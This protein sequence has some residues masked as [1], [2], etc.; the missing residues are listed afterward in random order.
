MGHFRC[1]GS[2][3]LAV[4]GKTRIMKKA[5][6]LMIASLVVFASCRK[7]AGTLPEDNGCGERVII[8]V[9]AH[10]INP[11]DVST[12][13]N[14][15]SKNGI[16]NSQLRYNRYRHDTLE[17]LYAPYTKYD[18]K[19]IRVD[20][21]TNGV[22]IF[23]G[24]M[25]FHFLN[26]SLSF[27]AGVPTKG[28]SLNTIPTLNA[29]QLRKLFLHDLERFDRAADKYKDTCFK[30]EFGYYNL[31]VGIGNA[32]ERLVKAWRVTSKNLTAPSKYPEAFYKDENGDLISY[33][34]GIRTFR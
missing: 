1:N 19:N 33:D 6:S 20:Q 18:Q 12:A 5:L 11:A 24:E 34:N 14:L 3:I 22:R 17:T 32:P 21:Y 8:P 16:D 26:D 10:N 23:Y 2:L 28:T 9:S 27:Q 4:T 30:C 31:N 25:T 29:R 13:N 7:P 15:F